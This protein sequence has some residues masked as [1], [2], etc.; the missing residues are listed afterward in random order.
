[1]EKR[2]NKLDEFVLGNAQANYSEVFLDH[3][4]HPRNAG[5]L[6]GAN[7]FATLHDHDGNPMEIWLRVDGENIQDARFWTE[8]CGTTIACGSMVTEMVK[9]KPLADAFQ[10]DPADIE[11]ALGD[12]PGEGCTCAELAVATLKAAVRDYLAFK[13]EP[14]RRSYLK[15]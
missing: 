7:G 2:L 1:M 10:L 3:A 9:G 12:L 8:G 11:S 13:K 4:L 6:E 15:P 5:N 14:W